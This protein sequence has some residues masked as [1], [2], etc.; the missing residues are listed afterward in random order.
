MKYCVN[1]VI[2][3]INKRFITICLIKKYLKIDKILNILEVKYRGKYGKTLKYDKI[4]NIL[5]VKYREK[6][7]KNDKMI[8]KVKICRI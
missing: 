4:L 5:I 1:M 6:I 2:L 3:R 7:D 8:E